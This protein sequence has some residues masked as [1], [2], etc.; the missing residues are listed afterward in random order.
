MTKLFNVLTSLALALLVNATVYADERHEHHEGW[1]G[2]IHR[3]HEHDINRWRGGHW[4]HGWHEGHYGWW[5]IVAGVGYSYPRPIYPY[6]D[7]YQPPVVIVQQPTQ[8]PVTAAPPNPPAPQTAPP[9]QYWYH[10]DN[11]A[12]YYPYVPQCPG[13]WQKVPVS[14]PPQ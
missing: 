1:H 7:P 10:C 6:P 3:F 9:P 2:D 8:P 12:G 13:G 14:P 11:P 4:L 5:W